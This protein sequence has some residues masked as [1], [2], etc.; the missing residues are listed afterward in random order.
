MA[1][2]AL[3]PSQLF[4]EERTSS[5]PN[6][7]RKPADL[8]FSIPA[9]KYTSLVEKSI[10]KSAI[11][12]PTKA[13]LHALVENDP[14]TIESAYKIYKSKIDTNMVKSYFGEVL[15]PIYLINE[16]KLGADSVVFPVRSNYELFDYFLGS[17]K[18]YTGYS[19]KVAGGSSNT[20]APGIIN[21]RITK[22][23]QSGGF[24]GKT[25]IAAE[26][27]EILATK[28]I[29]SGLLLSVGML[30]KN[31]ML[32][33]SM[34]SAQISNLKKINYTRDASILAGN[35]IGKLSKLGLSTPPAYKHL[36][37]T[38]VLPRLKI[39]DNDKKKYLAVKTEYTAT[40]IVYGMGMIIVDANKDG[41]FDISDLIRKTFQDLNVLKIGINATTG[42]PTYELKN[43]SQTTDTYMFRSKYR[44][45]VVKDKLGLQL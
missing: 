40:N 29:F 4:K 12:Q 19:A 17:K 3:A 1:D 42:I 38:Y 30:A 7:I 10:D 34:T 15:G 26:I 20:L 24:S 11:N 2:A 21:D 39:Y 33:S 14:K 16:K 44:W 25:K 6:L 41:K 37:D 45:D 5:I 36:M 22:I 13:Y 27:M 31:N 43:I 32:P 35:K 18:G 23:K 8:F 28:D 9:S